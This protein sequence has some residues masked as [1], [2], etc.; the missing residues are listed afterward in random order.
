MERTLIKQVNRQNMQAR[1]NTRAV[2]PVFFPNFFG[3]RQKT[4]LTWETLTGEKGAP[5]IADIISY[6]SSAP[7]KKR[8]VVGKMSG[9]IP[10]TAVKR[11]MNESD[12]NEYQQLSRDVGSDAN[13][14]E[15]L[16]LIFKDQDFVFNAV[17]GRFEWWCMQLLSK[18]GFAL[19]SEN[20]N[21]LVT[22]QFVACGM[23][24]DNR[25]VSKID[26][27]SSNTADGLQDIEDVLAAAAQKGVF[28]K[29]VIM[30]SDD[31]SLLKKQKATIEKLKGWV[32][33][34][35]KLTVTTQVINDYLAAQERPVRI[36]I[37]DP[38]VRIEDSA[39][40]RT[41]VNPWEKGRICFV[42]DLKIGDIQHGP[43]AAEN[44]EAYKKKAITTKQ[45]FVFISKWSELEPFKEWT[46][47]EANAIPVINDP[48]AM[49]IL[50][51]DGKEW[52][53]ND[54]E[55]TDRSPAPT[56]GNNDGGNE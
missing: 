45:G 9:D 10:K 8:E 17:R 29:Y 40:Q 37:V 46:K 24:K 3:T 47:A 56:G 34:Q 28:P 36:V 39:H 54:T 32:N 23:P 21:G 50:K 51:A 41:T 12:W 22:E 49:F 18:G 55:A 7:Q 2:K 38:A 16:D 15:L 6:D 27:N 25:K 33:F 20:N 30:R 31:F 11:G 44:S 4:T 19:S 35:T 48:E 26:W 5:V 14:R 42:E 1:L 13:Q 53:D 43:I 52:D